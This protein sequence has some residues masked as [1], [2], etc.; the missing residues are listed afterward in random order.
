MLATLF[1]RHLDT[2]GEVYA[3]F[4]FNGEWTDQEKEIVTSAIAPHV[5]ERVDAV[6]NNFMFYKF[7]EKNFAARRFTWEHMEW[8]STSAEE[9]ALKIKKYYT[10]S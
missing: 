9:L 1:I 2:R 5:P 10:E 8:G 3:P 7:G 6:F 4:G